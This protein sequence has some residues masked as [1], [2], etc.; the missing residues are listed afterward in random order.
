M[1]MLLFFV[2]LK[3]GYGKTVDGER[4]RKNEGEG[5]NEKRLI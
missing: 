4:E 1:M 2:H 5:A 3:K